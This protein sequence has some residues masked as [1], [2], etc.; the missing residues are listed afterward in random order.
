MSEP[1]DLQQVGIL[2]RN[3][4][5]L[6]RCTGGHPVPSLE[7]LDEDVG[8]IRDF[9]RQAPPLHLEGLEAHNLD[10]DIATLRILLT[11]WLELQ[12]KA[13]RGYGQ[14]TCSMEEWL[15]RGT[16]RPKIKLVAE[17]YQNTLGSDK[18][19]DYFRKY[20]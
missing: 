14:I 1:L 8:P 3:I 19:I 5:R 9:P 15:L 10:C 7:W 20:H 6:I 13:T 2:L 16:Q 18:S 17:V 4:F 12:P 11:A